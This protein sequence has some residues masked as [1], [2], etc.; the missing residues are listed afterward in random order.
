MKNQNGMKNSQM[1]KSILVA[2]MAMLTMVGCANNN[3][4]NGARL[5]GRN[6]NNAAAINTTL[7]GTGNLVYS[8]S[9]T[10]GSATAAAQGL[11][12]LSLPSGSNMGTVDANNGMTITGKVHFDAA[13][14]TQN[15]ISNQSYVEIQIKDSLALS[16]PNQY[17]PFVIAV[18]MNSSS[19]G[20]LSLVSGQNYETTQM[21][22]QDQYGW[23]MISGN[24]N[25]TTFN[26][27][28]YYGS[29]QYTTATSW[30]YLGDFTTQSCG[31]FFTCQ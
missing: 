5:S 12:Q 2:T 10:G 13:S 6:P 25:T 19:Y 26:G 14:P 15:M 27:R 28:V 11:L 22:F 1:A 4:N 9:V 3:S 20:T 17:G 18:G 8:T 29:G 31:G 30:T 21:V 16:N 7:A 23:I 24:L